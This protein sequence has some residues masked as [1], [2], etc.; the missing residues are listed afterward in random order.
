MRSKTLLGGE[1]GKVKNVTLFSGKALKNEEMLKQFC[2]ICSAKN[3]KVIYY[4][5]LAGN[6][7]DEK[8]PHRS[9]L[10]AK[11]LSGNYCIDSFTSIES[12]FLTVAG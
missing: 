7:N 3:N 2:K 11:C 10:C 1:G 5:N 6:D 12:S 9:D 8:R 4:S